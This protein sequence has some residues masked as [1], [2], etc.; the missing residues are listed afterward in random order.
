MGDAREKNTALNAESIGYFDPGV[1]V[2]RLK[3][4]NL[5]HWRQDGVM[6]FVT[7]RLDDSIPQTRIHLWITERDE[8]LARHTPPYDNAEQEE[9]NEMFTQ[10]FMRW[11]D[12]GYGECILREPYVRAVVADT[13]RH[14]DGIRYRL[15]D[16]VIMPNH[17]HVLISPLGDW[18][19]SKIVHSWKSFTAL[20]INRILKRTGSV[21]QKES[22]DH[23]VRSPE[24][25]KRIV[26]YIR[27]NPK[28]LRSGSF[29]VSTSPEPS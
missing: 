25:H 8:W 24:S 2:G 9:F 26:C 12:A 7:F 10:R 11:L 28:S 13:L 23:I 17:V 5:P 6:Y 15:G 19:L 29:S 14:F 16:W 27:N 18:K 3:G 1:A 20:T 22:F 21:W 4:G